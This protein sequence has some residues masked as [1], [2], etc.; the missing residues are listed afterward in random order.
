MKPIRLSELGDLSDWQNLNQPWHDL[1]IRG[2]LAWEQ[3]HTD[4]RNHCDTM[5][6]I[7]YGVKF[8]NAINLIRRRR[9]QMFVHSHLYYNL[10]R[11]LIPDLQ[12]DKWAKELALLQKLYP[13]N[14]GFYDDHFSD[15]DG[16]TGFH[17]E[18]PTTYRMV[19][20]DLFLNKDT[21]DDDIT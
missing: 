15:W 10:D 5:Q 6:K 3:L 7:V 11:S 17:L 2:D 19:A 13:S 9:A 4:I 21:Y 16:N 20:H 14:L 8:H 1:S 12:F 18:I